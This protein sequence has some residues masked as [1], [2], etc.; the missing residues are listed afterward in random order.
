MARLTRQQWHTLIT[1]FESSN[2][3]QADFCK[4]H[5]LN[6][7]YFSLKR[8]KFLKSHSNEIDTKPF[9]K[10]KIE[11]PASTGSSIEL[12]T[13]RVAIKL[14]PGVPADYVAQLARALA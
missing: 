6:P 13:G 1:D 8:S 9:V 4:Q 14:S 7:K 5:G 3:S 10:A 12:T 11:H 2:L